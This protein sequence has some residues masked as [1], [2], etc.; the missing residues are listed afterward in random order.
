DVDSKS[1]LSLTSL[2]FS[3]LWRFFS[4]HDAREG[5]FVFHFGVSGSREPFRVRLIAHEVRNQGLARDALRILAG[6]GFCFLPFNL[7]EY[8]ASRRLNVELVSILL[9]LD[10][11]EYL[12]WELRAAYH[13]HRTT[14]EHFKLVEFLIDLVERF[15]VLCS[16]SNGLRLRRWRD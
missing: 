6:Q 10:S 7:E 11:F 8:A 14:V 5:A 15:E 3:G 4:S 1:D 2:I 16:C 13:P 9:L 12:L